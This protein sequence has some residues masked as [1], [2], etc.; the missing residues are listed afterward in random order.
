MSGSTRRRAALTAGIAA[1]ATFL[2]STG[3]AWAA[4]EG[5]IQ[6]VESSPGVIDF[7]FSAEGL[8]EG[9]SINP[10]SVDVT[11][12]GLEAP[13]T[14]TSISDAAAAPARTVMLTLDASGSMAD[15]G[16]LSIAKSAANAYLDTLPEDVKVGLVS[17]SDTAEVEVAP[18]L[19][20]T[21][22]AT[23][24]DALD[25]KGG[26]ALNDA[27]IVTTEQLGAEGSRNMVLLSDGN[28]A[29]SEASGK[30]ARAVVAESGVI[31]D[32]VSLG[33]GSQEKPLAAFARAGNG[34]VVTATSLA[35]LTAAF[36]SAA[37]SVE[38]Q[39]AVRASVP[40]GVEAGTVELSAA[41]LVGEQ[42]I[43]DTTA[44]IITSA[45]QPSASA[46][47]AFGA[48]AAPNQEPGLFDQTWVLIA[49]IAV[50]FV[51]L[52]TIASLAVGAVDSKNRKEGRV[53]RRLEEVSSIGGVQSA[54]ITAAAQ[55]ETRLGESVAVRKAVSF[56][57]R[58]AASRDTTAIA[59]KLEAAN[60]TMRPGEW[61][62]VHALIAVLAALLTTLFTGFNVLLTVIAFV[63]GLLIPWMYLGRRADK[64]KTDFYDELP[65]AMQM[66]A[67]SLSAGYSLPQA[68]DNVSKESAGPLGQELNRSLLESRLG[69]PL[70]ETLEATAQRMDSKD[71][72]WV[73]MAIRINRKVGGNLAEVLTNV[74]KTLRE[75]ERLR[76]QVKTL[77]AEG[78]LSGW[79]L[80]ALPLL[81]LVYMFVVRP[82]YITPL[83]TQPIGWVILGAGVVSYVIGIIWMRNL[84]NME[85]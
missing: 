46:S 31:L 80:G 13:S 25:A 42:P 49:V 50:I 19:D 12:A 70:E 2:L 61:V 30:E 35:A 43:T 79:I 27:V 66:L 47:D 78:R 63:L 26:T 32:A 64:R 45:P 60:V 39:L 74:G 21:A 84:V 36:E 3:V 53:S 8:V 73:V 58:V 18:T 83:F 81:L 71:F 16:K 69:L 59:S 51:A 5:R 34:S 68:L 57:D 75:R 77:S 55:S 65:E 22:V 44:T 48:V 33:E 52:A 40:E 54:E 9:E 23:A 4:P 72:H 1:A 38:N 20:R 76:R 67:G 17:F 14:A 29:D 7:V 6:Q 85:V 11:I 15:F 37:R 28:D 10:E 82:E 62:V 24:V 41:A 56:A